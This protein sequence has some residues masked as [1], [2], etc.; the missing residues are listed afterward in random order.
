VATRGPGCPFVSDIQA[1]SAAP[2]EPGEPSEAATAVITGRRARALTIALVLAVTVNAFEA[3]AVVTA[4]PEI[5][6]ALDGDSLYGA[7]FSAY[8]LANL[9]AL[10]ATGEI[11]DR[12]GPAFPFLL[13]V[14]CFCV[15]LLVAGLAP[16]MP[17][18]VLG[19]AIQGIGGG[20]LYSVAYVTV[21]RG[22]PPDRRPKVIA[23]LSSAWVIPSLAGP[24]L[25]GA[26][27][28]HLSWRLV[29]LGLLPL[30][31]VLIALALPS[32][33]ALPA[34]PRV[35]PAPRSRIPDA[36][37]LAVATGVFVGGLQSDRWWILVPLTVGGAVVAVPPLRRLLPVGT[38]RARRGLPAAAGARGL[39]NMAFFGTDTF[40]PLAVTRLHGA[41]TL[42]AGFMI[43]GASLTWTVGSV[44]QARN[45][46][47]WV[48]GRTI[49]VGF[50][51]IAVGIAAASVVLAP[52][53]PFGLVLP[54]WAIAGFGMGFVFN[55]TAL[56]ALAY[57]KPGEEGLTISQLQL[58]DALGFALIGAVAGALIGAGER[59]GWSLQGPL[60]ATFLLCLC[61][62]LAGAWVGSRVR[63]PSTTD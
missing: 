52:S 12:R 27:T 29:F 11:T 31:P 1:A 13:G 45:A 8:F 63:G 4:M 17:V 34:I 10:V 50:A 58:S 44:L 22:F 42:A 39:V 14:G 60:L 61:L 62:A 43:V 56:V 25:A 48:A 23:A 15:G 49:A 2:S 20:T 57:A 9:V 47:R 53:L 40:I 41:G 16:S 37:L 38:F 5:S 28:E 55:T 18:L 35:G 21:G 36:V 30:L 32:L 54:A 59:A 24:A 46:Q 33:R 3:V 7:A 19:R 51:I 26:V 6:K